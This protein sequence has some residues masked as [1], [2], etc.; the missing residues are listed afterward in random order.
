MRVFQLPDLQSK[1]PHYAGDDSLKGFV[2]G[3]LCYDVCYR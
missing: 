2:F 1:A 3:R